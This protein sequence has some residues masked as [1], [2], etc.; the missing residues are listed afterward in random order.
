MY[1]SDTISVLSDR[2]DDAVS[3]YLRRRLRSYAQ[4]LRDLARQ[5]TE[6]G[7]PVADTPDDNPG[8]QNGDDNDGTD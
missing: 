3:P 4:Y 2:N 5:K 6:G 8:S 7:K 1:F